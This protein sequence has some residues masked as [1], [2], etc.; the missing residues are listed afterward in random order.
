[1]NGF[2][3]F[4][5]LDRETSWRSSVFFVCIT[6]ILTVAGFFD[7]LFPRAWSKMLITQPDDCLLLFLVQPIKFD[8]IIIVQEI[9][10]V[11]PQG[12]SVTQY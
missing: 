7:F 6:E 12:V 9:P 4:L 10:T 3:W 2:G 8:F 1:M 11:T 5:Y